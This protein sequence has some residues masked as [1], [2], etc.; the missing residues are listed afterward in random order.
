MKKRLWLIPLLLLLLLAAAFFVYT[1]SYYRA[2]A[3]AL[4]ALESDAVAV[5]R[6][7][8]GWR[9]DG[10]ASD[11][12]L[13]FYPGAKVDAAA[14]AP[15]L[16]RMAESGIDVCLVEMP[17][18]LALFGV[19]RAED[20]MARYAYDNWYIGGH[21]LGGVMAVRFAAAH[22][23]SGI[24][25]LASYPIDSVEE[26]ILIVYGS[27]DGVLKRDRVEEA[28][29]LD[30]VQTVVIEGGNHAGFGS[31]GAQAGDRAAAIGA[32]EQ[33]ER[34]V[35]AITAWLSPAPLPEA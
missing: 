14:Y 2:D 10:P 15:L 17:F 24:V 6:T 7:D 3:A 5:E 34:T 25:L 20:V 30:A 22:D 28:A 29:R 8:F 13:I 19:N 9:F 12:A 31:Y 32:E 21:S 33:Q 16:H 18:H 35:A 1:G 11:T 27:E 23:L 26:P 4:S